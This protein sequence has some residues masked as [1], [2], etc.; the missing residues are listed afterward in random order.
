MTF[1]SKCGRR[2]AGRIN[3]RLVEFQDGVAYRSKPEDET[4]PTWLKDIISNNMIYHQHETTCVH[5]KWLQRGLKS[6]S[7]RSYRDEQQLPFYGSVRGVHDP[8]LTLE[9]CKGGSI[10]HNPPTSPQSFPAVN[11]DS[12]TADEDED[13]NPFVGPEAR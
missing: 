7:N 9:Q 5:D 3:G 6:S 2:I 8:P 12:E 1:L 10:P 11:S 13:E 4:F